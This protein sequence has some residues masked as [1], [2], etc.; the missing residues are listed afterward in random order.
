MGDNKDGQCNVSDWTDI[1]AISAGNRH[2]VGLRS[3]GRV[4]AVGSNECG[5]CDV[6]NFKLFNDLDN[7]EEEKRLAREKR[8]K[9][10][11]I[12]REKRIEEERIALEKKKEMERVAEQR[13]REGLCPYCG[14]TFKGLFTKKCSNC[15]KPKDY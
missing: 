3:D 9:E 11:R 12:A 1:V 10:E 13:R 15:G 5:R 8:I 2:T 7:L 6:S 4:V 14:G